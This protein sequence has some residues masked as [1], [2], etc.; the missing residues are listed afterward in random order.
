M[1]SINFVCH[2]NICRSPMAEF[3]MKELVKRKGLEN[4]FFIDSAA[5]SREEI[6][7]GVHPGT[8][9]KLREKG[10]P[11]G[12][13]D[14]KALCKADNKGRL[15]KLRLHNHHGQVK[16][17]SFVQAPEP[18]IQPKGTPPFEFCRNGQGH[19]GPLVHRKL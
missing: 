6:G 4:R 14:F 16:H 17:I 1:T 15:R 2:G 5:V 9:E 7:N 13:S 12:L 3:V 18:G 11:K 8:R 19:K 10:F